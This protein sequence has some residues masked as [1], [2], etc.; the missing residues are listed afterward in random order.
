MATRDPRLKEIEEALQ[1]V[2]SLDGMANNFR[3]RGKVAL[4]ETKSPGPEILKAVKMVA[5]LMK[6]GVA[7]NAVMNRL[8]S[9]YKI[10]QNTGAFGTFA[11]HLKKENATLGEVAS[12]AKQYTTLL[13]DSTLHNTLKK[14]SISYE[15][16]Y[17]YCSQYVAHYISF[18][19]DFNKVSKF[20]DD[21]KAKSADPNLAKV[22]DGMTVGASVEGMCENFQ[23]RGKVAVNELKVAKKESKDKV[24]IKEY[25]AVSTL[26]EALIKSAGQASAEFKAMLNDYAVAKK[27]GDF[28][29]CAV[30]MKSRSAAF[31]IVQQNATDLSTKLKAVTFD[32]KNASKHASLI[33]LMNYRKIFDAHYATFKS[34]I[35]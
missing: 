31:R 19:K 15:G 9:D 30:K 12:L 32:A 27:D 13:S 29:A 33:G 20:K 18:A 21:D 7:V 10:V 17:Q 16:M 24:Q 22:Q 23:S 4:S 8:L 14:T 6:G 5:N 34:V 28:G 35:G 26:V 11:A 25:D 2:A 3:T 1:K